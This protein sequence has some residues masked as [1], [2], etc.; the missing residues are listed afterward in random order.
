MLKGWFTLGFNT[1]MLKLN[2]HMVI[3]SN[4]GRA[5]NTTTN[6]EKTLAFVNQHRTKHGLE[7]ITELPKGMPGEATNCVVARA[8]NE[9]YVTTTASVAGITIYGEDGKMRRL[10]T[11]VAVADFI[12]AFDRD[13]FPDLIDE[14]AEKGIFSF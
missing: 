2:K 9:V 1:K 4:M 13:Y 7:A 8:L 3:A 12:R 11:P 14:E 5:T 10:R 6:R